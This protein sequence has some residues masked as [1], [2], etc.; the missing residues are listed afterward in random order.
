MEVDNFGLNQRNA[1][2]R[3]TRQQVK[4]FAPTQKDNRKR[5]KNASPARDPATNRT[6]TG[7]PSRVNPIDTEV[8][9]DEPKYC[10]CN[11]VSY[12]DVCSNF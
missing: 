11:Q 10:Y 5:M 9:S 6:Q 12:G 1:R 4:P 7:P 3:N 8:L 2:R